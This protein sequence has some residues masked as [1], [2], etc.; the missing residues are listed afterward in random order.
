VRGEAV[1]GPDPAAGCDGLQE[2]GRVGIV[3]SHHWDHGAG[4]GEG[5]SAGPKIQAGSLDHQEE[6][7]EGSSR[8]RHVREAGVP[9]EDQVGT[10]DHRRT[11]LARQAVTS[12]ASGRA[13]CRLGR[14]LETV[15]RNQR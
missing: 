14:I 3:H 1:E 6:A 15:E 7:H 13:P 11:G 9:S 2:A 4:H 5:P 10:G 12:T 8:D